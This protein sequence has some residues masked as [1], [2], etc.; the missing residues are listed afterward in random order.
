M[1]KTTIR[2]S[3]VDGGNPGK[4]YVSVNG[5]EES[6]FAAG[7]QGTATANWIKQGSVY[8]F[9]LYDSDHTELLAKVAVTRAT[10]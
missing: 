4:I 5:R 1:G 9:R 6:L 8:E 2:W 10:Q 3:A 7:C